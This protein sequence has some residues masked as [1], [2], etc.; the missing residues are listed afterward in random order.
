MRGKVKYDP[1]RYM[2]VGTCA[3]QMIE[4][5]EERKEGVYSGESLAIGAARVGGKEEIFV[6]STLRELCDADEKLGKPLHSL[7][8]LGRRVHELEHEFVRESAVDKENWDRIWK[9][10]YHQS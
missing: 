1:P 6:A 8:L 3:R 7:V 2:T 10:E 9:A 5:E 4:T